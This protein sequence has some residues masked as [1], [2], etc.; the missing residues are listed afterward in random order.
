MTQSKESSALFFSDN[1]VTGNIWPG[2][3][4]ARWWHTGYSCIPSRWCYSTFCAHCPRLS[5]QNLP[6][7]RWIVKEPSRLWT[8]RS[9]EFVLHS[10]Y[11]I[12]PSQSSRLYHPDY[13]RWT[14]QTMKFL[15]VEPSPLPILI[16]HGS[17]YSSLG[18]EEDH[19]GK[20][21]WWRNW[22]KGLPL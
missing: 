15:I 14:V 2:T 12:C 13:I 20:F 9:P 18:I 1:S 10:G 6:R 7:R 17:K 4:P 21:T 5:E 8:S 3:A 22:L 16:P 19:E 11:M